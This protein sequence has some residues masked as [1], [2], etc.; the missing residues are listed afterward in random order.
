[1][2]ESIL[3]LPGTMC[4]ELLWEDCLPYL[5][6]DCHFESA[7][8]F[9][10]DNKAEMHEI[11]A[12]ELQEPTHVVGFSLGAYLALEHVLKFPAQ[13]VKSLVLIAGSARG[14]LPQEIKARE[15]ILKW[16]ETN[17]YK[18][19]NSARLKQLLS[20]SALTNEQIVAKI[21]QM[22]QELGKDVLTMQFQA[23]TYRED[24]MDK[25]SQIT[26]PVLLVGAEND[27]LVAVET[28]QQMAD[29]IPNATLV[30]APDCGHMIPLESPKW[31]AEQLNS[32]VVS[33]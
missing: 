25:L 28:L 24:L 12:A 26:V 10:A 3:F 5:S 13:S 6:T 14:L 4:T 1:M 19:I 27:A 32:W 29:N 16:I 21:K 22:D 18:G 33:N 17:T 7:S 31:L 2:S 30:I 20:E 23:T 8:I 9:Q 15:T 11:V